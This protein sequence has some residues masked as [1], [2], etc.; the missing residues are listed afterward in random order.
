MVL[1]YIAHFPHY[2]DKGKALADALL[3]E[4]FSNIDN[5]EGFLKAKLPLTKKETFISAGFAGSS[6]DKE[7]S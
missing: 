4:Q 5:P 6:F 2:V 3:L 7:P 1:W